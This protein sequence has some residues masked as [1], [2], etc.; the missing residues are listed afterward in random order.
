MEYSY[1]IDEELSLKSDELRKAAFKKEWNA[2][3]D[4]I[5]KLVKKQQ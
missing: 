3:Q 4:I 5:I 2:I 1:L